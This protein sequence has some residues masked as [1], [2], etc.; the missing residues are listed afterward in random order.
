MKAWYDLK[1]KQELV[2][3]KLFQK[4]QVLNEP[5]KVYNHVYT[6]FNFNIQEQK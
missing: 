6:K 4:L 1:T 3:R 5:S 2:N